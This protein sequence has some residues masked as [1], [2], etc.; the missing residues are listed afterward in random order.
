MQIKVIKKIKI[1]NFLSLK[2]F[3]PFIELP[4]RAG[5]NNNESIIAPFP[6]ELKG[7]SNLV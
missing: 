3:K 5:K 1:N 4:I 6:A 7:P 2:N